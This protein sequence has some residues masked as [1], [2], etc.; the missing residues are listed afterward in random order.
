MDKI[1]LGLLG[2]G[3]WGPRYAL[4]L[5]DNPAAELAVAADL[6]IEKAQRIAGAAPR[7]RA[8]ADPQELYQAADVDGILIVTP[9]PTH[10]ML[11]CAALQAGK[12]VLVEKPLGLNLAEARAIVAA[13]RQAGRTLMVGQILRFMPTFDELRRRVQ[14]GEIGDVLR[15]T[16][17]R[18]GQFRQDAWPDWWQRMYGFL[19]FHLGTHSIDASLWATGARPAWAFAQGLARQVNP[20]YGAIDAFGLLVGCVG[21]VQVTL[22]HETIG[23]PHSLRQHLKI[24][25]TRGVL[26]IKQFNQLIQNDQLV[27]EVGA[28]LYPGAIL[29]EVN[30]FARA[31]RSGS[32]PSVAGRDVLATA[33][34]LDAGARSLRSDI[35]ETVEPYE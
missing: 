7:A 14:T 4:A 24:I 27:L 29:A 26:E 32:E 13:A 25:G 11:A 21:D 16:E 3:S 8:V 18:Y 5:Q 19:L 6:D 35:R 22:N 10:R 1:R 30:E 2:C 17:D 31:I 23:G 12:H 15:V 28:D 34:A 20:Q 33:A 9:T